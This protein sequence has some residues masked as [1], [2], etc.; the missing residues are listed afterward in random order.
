ME[1][2]N[3]YEYTDIFLLNYTKILYILSHFTPWEKDFR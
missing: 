3:I 1:T 2:L